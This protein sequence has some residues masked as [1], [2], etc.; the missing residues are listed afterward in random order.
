MSQISIKP[1]DV[2]N[3]D[4][5]ECRSC[6]HEYSTN[7]EC[8]G[9]NLVN[10]ASLSTDDF[11]S[12]LHSVGHSVQVDDDGNEKNYNTLLKS[13][14]LTNL[15][16][17]NLEGSWQ[18]TLHAVM[19]LDN[20]NT[21]NCKSVSQ[22]IANLLN[23]RQQICTR[24][25]R[26]SSQREIV[27]KQ[28]MGLRNVLWSR[29][30]YSC[31]LMCDTVIRRNMYAAVRC[32]EGLIVTERQHALLD[33]LTQ[34]A[35]NAPDLEHLKLESK[36]GAFVQNARI[37]LARE[38]ANAM[39]IF[40]KSQGNVVSGTLGTLLCHTVKPFVVQKM[41]AQLNR[42]QIRQKQLPLAMSIDHTYRRRSKNAAMLTSPVY[43]E[44]LA[45]ETQK[46][47][48]RAQLHAALWLFRLMSAACERKLIPGRVFAHGQRT[49]THALG[50]TKVVQS[51]GMNLAFS[52]KDVA[53]FCDIFGFE[54]RPMAR[55]ALMNKQ[56][57]GVFSWLKMTR[58][59]NDADNHLHMHSKTSQH[60]DSDDILNVN[61]D[62]LQVTL[63]KKMKQAET[64]ERGL[65]SD[66]HVADLTMDLLLKTV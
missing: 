37:L 27:D 35:M 43:L 25:E 14:I 12:A 22:N 15:F 64:N 49:L 34:A 51:T 18:D 41:C 1:Q 10:A 4:L 11:M 24:I 47:V 23:L 21:A 53:A 8:R 52:D 56:E 39:T 13:P 32:G 50:L 45:P 61:I 40:D 16:H 46:R 60:T 65:F 36:Q 20:K 26:N 28:E 31:L 17:A 58:H 19:D 29:T 48:P 42:D 5:Y 3:L 44:L 63:E 62:L 66:E 7:T 55:L 38:H 33:C 30:L 57:G 59:V 2:L 6:C 9:D 54:V